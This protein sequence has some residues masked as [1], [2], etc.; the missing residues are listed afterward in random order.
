MEKPVGTVYIALAETGEK[1]VVQR[2]QYQTD[3]AT[4]KDLV[5]QT[6]LDML[7]LRIV[8]RNTPGT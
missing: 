6:A 8:A 7:R 1:P 3:R 2:H 5:S 4:F